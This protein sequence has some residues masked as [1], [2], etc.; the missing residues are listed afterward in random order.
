[1]ALS[2]LVT[3]GESKAW[4]AELIERARALKVGNGFDTDVDL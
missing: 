3:V 1:M 2:V 4:V